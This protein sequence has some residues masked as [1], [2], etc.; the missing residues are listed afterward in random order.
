MEPGTLVVLAAVVVL[1]LI[2]GGGNIFHDKGGG[3]TIDLH[4]RFD[5]KLLQPA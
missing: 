2:F 4:Y 5:S 1:C 3:K